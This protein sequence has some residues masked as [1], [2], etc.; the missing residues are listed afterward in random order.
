MNLKEFIGDFTG[1]TKNL[2]Q[3]YQRYDNMSGESKKSMLDNKMTD[4]VENAVNASGLNFIVKWI[5]KK[6]IITQIPYITQIIFDLI[7]TKIKGITEEK[8]V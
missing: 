6:Y 1:K 3:I 7:K 5:I 4:F 2:I 8:A